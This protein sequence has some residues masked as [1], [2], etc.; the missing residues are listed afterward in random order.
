M[1]VLVL[2]T[3][4]SD[5]LPVDE[6]FMTLTAVASILSPPSPLFAGAVLNPDNTA[7]EVMR[8]KT[9]DLQSVQSEI[10]LTWSLLNLA[11]WLKADN[12]C[13]D[14]DRV[15]LRAKRA[16]LKAETY[17]GDLKGPESLEASSNLRLLKHVIGAIAPTG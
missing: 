17:A 11:N 15:V 8:A 9:L 3:D 16:M 12:K 1:E 14:A 2:G 7:S 6:D 5:G 13:L 10:D 4:R